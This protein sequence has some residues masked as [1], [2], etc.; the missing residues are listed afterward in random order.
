M[1]SNLDSLSKKLQRANAE[2]DR[3]KHIKETLQ[4]ENIELEEYFGE[5]NAEV[6]DIR[7]NTVKENDTKTNDE[8]DLRKQLNEFKGELTDLSIK[9]RSTD[10]VNSRNTENIAE[11]E[12]IVRNSS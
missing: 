2:E 10:S 12:G 1:A 8:R 4:S 9:E 7:R 11:L 6:S 3:L 5:Q